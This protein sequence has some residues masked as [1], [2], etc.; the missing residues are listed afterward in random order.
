MG[1]K[2]S[3]SSTGPAVKTKLV[4]VGVAILGAAALVAPAMLAMTAILF[5]ASAQAQQSPCYSPIGPVLD[6]G[7]PVRI[8]VVGRFT[9]TSEFGMRKLP[10]TGVL[11]LHSGLDLSETPANGSIVAAKDGVVS[12][13]PSDPDGGNQIY[14]SHG[15]GLETHYLHLTSRRV[16]VG[17]KVSAGQQIGIEGTSGQSTGPHLDFEVLMAGQ[18]MNPRTWLT[19]H[20]VTV[21][22][23]GVQGTAPGPT[24]TADT[25]GGLTFT[26]IMPAS[27]QSVAISPVVTQMPAQVGNYK[28]DQVLNGAYVIKAG[29][30]LSLDAWTITVGVMTAMGESSL[31]NIDHGD[32][33]GPDSRGLFQ[34]RGNGAWGSYA[35]RMNPTTAATNF[36]KA[37]IAVP[38]YHLVDPTIAAHRTQGNAD[39]Y[40]YAPFW[41]QAVQMVSVLTGDPSLLEQL[42]MNGSITG[43]ASDPAGPLPQPPANGGSGAAIAASAQHWI[44]TPYSW[45]GG[46]I[47]GPSLGIYSSASLDGTHSVG[48]DCSGLVLFAIYRGTGIQLDHSAENQSHSPRG[49]TIPRDFALMKPGDVIGFSEDGSG[50]SGSFGHIGIYVGGGKMIHAPRPGK[51]VEIVVLQGNPYF[52]SMAWSIKRFASS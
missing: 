50:A 10:A 2:A 14:I 27:S 51:N 46:N 28:G 38:G 6:T 18:P 39:P 36:F 35:D 22:P 47:N 11:K 17:D 43:C 9:P 3:A 44:G 15:G 16:K 30:A 32:T 45:G 20:G 12:A 7:G 31:I 40:Y 33:A 48:F 52:E 8:P 5:S 34:Q 25:S 19:Q 4:V 37:M 23:T 29:Q 13:I 21:P 24:P 49:Q 1:N 42:P 26:P 41:P